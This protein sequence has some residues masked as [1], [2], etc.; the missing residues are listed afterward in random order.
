MDVIGAG[1]FTVVFVT[2]WV[3]FFHN[4]R[5]RGLRVIDILGVSLSTAGT[6]LLWFV[7]IKTMIGTAVWEDFKVFLI[8]IMLAAF[9]PF[10]FR[11]WY[12]WFFIDMLGIREPKEFPVLFR[13]RGFTIDF[14]DIVFGL[15]YAY[16]GWFLLFK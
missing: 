1:I 9:P 2:C 14:V 3:A 12:S 15:T 11:K 10:W 8:G 13:S 4:I 16:I 6:A 7:A 5:R